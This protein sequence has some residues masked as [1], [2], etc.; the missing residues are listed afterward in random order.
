MDKISV[1]NR[2]TQNGRDQI[3]KHFR[4]WSGRDEILDGRKNGHDMCIYQFRMSKVTEIA[5]F[6]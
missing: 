3:L 2:W 5:P 4:T 6:R 1:T